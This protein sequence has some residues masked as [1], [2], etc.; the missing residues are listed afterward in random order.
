[1]LGIYS[2]YITISV[3]IA[4]CGGVLWT[5]PGPRKK[6]LKLGKTIGG[7]GLS[8]D[9]SR[10]F[11]DQTIRCRHIAIRNYKLDR[12]IVL[13]SF[14]LVFLCTYCFT[15]HNKTREESLY[16]RGLGLRTVQAA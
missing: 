16:V 1:M 15:T 8:D 7:V 4:N 12:K 11:F 10:I 2:Y 6:R 14:A 9:A 13:S 5:I 3:L